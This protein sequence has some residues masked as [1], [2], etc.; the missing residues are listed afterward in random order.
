MVDRLRKRAD[1]LIALTVTLAGFFLYARTVAPSV[2]FADSGEFQ[3]ATYIAGIAHSTGYPLYTMLGWAWT[4]LLPMGSVAFRLNL[5][6]ALWGG[7]TLGL[8]YGV[9][10]RVFRLAAPD[11]PLSLR[12]A[13]SVL[14]ALLLAVSATFW[15]QVVVAE[16]AGLNAAFVAVVLY[17]A[18]G[19]WESTGAGG[20]PDQRAPRL[21]ALAAV[22]GLSLTHHRTMILLLPAL[23]VPVWIGVRR[24]G[25]GWLR[26]LRLALPG[27]LLPQLLYLY[28]PLR[29]GHTPYAELSLG[30]GQTLTLYS[31]SVSG[32][33]DLV[34]GR[35]FAGDLASGPLDAHRLGMLLDLGLQQFGWVGIGLGL[36]GV[37]ALVRRRAWLVLALTALG[38]LAYVAFSA[39][40][41]IGDVYPLL[42]PAYLIW[43]LWIS[44]GVWEIV[45]DVSSLVFRG[46]T[47]AAAP[48]IVLAFALP[49][50]WGVHNFAAVDQ[51]HNREAEQMWQTILS[52]PI[53]RDAILVSNDRDEIMPLWYYQYVDGRRPDVL[54][55]FPLIVRDPAYRDVSGVIDRA[56]ASG[57]PVFLAKPMPGLELKYR[58]KPASGP[59]V[60]VAASYAGA[61]PAYPL[62]MTLGDAMRLIGYDLT[63]ERPA[64]GQS[65]Q[66]TLYWQPLRALDK[67]YSSFVHFVNLPGKTI[68]KDDHPLGGAYYPTKQWKA[69]EVLLDA[70]RV[71]IPTGSAAGAYSVTVGLYAWPSMERPG[72]DIVI[73]QVTF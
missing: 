49:A 33:L 21:V 25:W 2:L 71:D 64:A 13:L 48:V 27:L 62:D 8:V 10:L 28:I 1:W 59:L 57:R 29:A 7:I 55:L 52:Q 15:G 17:L 60:R 50:F 38:G 22:Y 67:E 46:R 34:L 31:R 68:I 39:I 4:H 73:G 11:C 26:M 23:A 42:I 9:A 14:T 5:F 44:L 40:Y 61:H 72:P 45:G 19:F 3:F 54:G 43:A 18:L 12:R 58:L 32:F 36:I 6:S 70:H 47:S 35:A 53:P 66:V 20:R 37:L 63:P 69:G 41:F 56:L 16:S 51:S 24:A 65:A 30:A